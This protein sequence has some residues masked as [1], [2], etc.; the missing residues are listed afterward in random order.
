MPSRIPTSARPCDSPAVTQRRPFISGA[1][2]ARSL[3]GSTCCA[4]SQALVEGDVVEGHAQLARAELH[5]ELAPVLVDARDLDPLL[6]LG[7]PD[8]RV[9]LERGQEA[10]T[11]RG[12]GRTAERLLELREPAL[13]LRAAGRR[14]LRQECPGPGHDGPRAPDALLD[15][16]LRL[17]LELGAARGELGLGLRQHRPRALE[18]HCS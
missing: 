14:E 5:V 13:E 18:L 16:A 1:R 6:E 8:E 7:E 2:Y 12:E 10:C 11:P 9:L 17:G 15:P 4:G 3:A